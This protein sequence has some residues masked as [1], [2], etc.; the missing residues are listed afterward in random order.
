MP[1]SPLYDIKTLLMQVGEGNE[2]AFRAVFDFF[3]ERFYTASLRMTQSADIAE[4]IVQEVFVTLWIKRTQVAK[5]INPENYLLTVLHNCIYAHFRK[6][7]LEKA[8]KK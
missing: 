5:A 7:A 8:L 6:L 4:E 2:P 3:R 1:E